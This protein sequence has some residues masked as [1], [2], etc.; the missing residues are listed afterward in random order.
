[1]DSAIDI[2]KRAKDEGLESVLILLP[3]REETVKHGEEDFPAN[4]AAMGVNQG[5]ALDSGSSPAEVAIDGGGKTVSL[6]AGSR[7]AVLTIGGGVVLTLR[8]IVF[9]GHA[10]NNAPLLYVKEGGTLIFENGAGVRD[11][12]NAYGGSSRLE[13]G[14][15]LVEG[16]FLMR[17]GTISGN[18]AG[19]VVDPSIGGGFAFRRL[20]P[21]E[22]VGDSHG[23][24][25]YINRQGV[26]TMSG[27][28]VSGNYASGDGGGVH[29]ASGGVF[30][31]SGGELRSNYAGR[32]GGGASID[33]DS[34]FTLSGGSVSGNYAGSNGGG[35]AANGARFEMS[36][37][38]LL[39]NVAKSYGGGALLSGGAVFAKTNAGNTAGSGV[40]YG[41]GAEGNTNIAGNGNGYAVYALR[42]GAR[43]D[44][45]AGEADALYYNAAP[46]PDRGWVWPG[47]R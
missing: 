6:D 31:M 39:G 36:G 13:G 33:R 1:M 29:I 21:S 11:N 44:V 20:R 15:V 22:S 4:P 17:G 14:G 3:G 45:T 32:N 23:G 43:R 28:S 7:G 47:G 37:G 26:F 40:I 34:A 24:G 30:A 46:N 8:N 42:D 10:D 19:T 16:E 5:L 18:T 41:L 2:L 38:I 9:K 12:S 25:V 27:G 35:V